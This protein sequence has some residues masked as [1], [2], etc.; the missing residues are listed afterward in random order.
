MPII[1]DTDL[2]AYLGIHDTEDATGISAAA[3]AGSQAVVEYCGRSFDKTALAS[4]TARVFRAGLYDCMVDDFWETT[5]LIVKLDYGADGTYESTW[6]INT[7][8]YL[9]PLNG[10]LGGQTWPYSR[11]VATNARTFPQASR[12]AVQVTAAW[13]WAAVPDAVRQATLIKAAKLFKR[14]DSVE[15]VIGGF[16]DF[17]P[18]RISRFEDPDVVGLLGPYR[19]PNVAV[20]LA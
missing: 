3:A 16:A 13:G 12:P 15:G 18:A 19:R 20:L 9:E 5:A 4:P 10:L 11:I 14:K 8:F 17:G 6:T 1:A 7:D 2:G